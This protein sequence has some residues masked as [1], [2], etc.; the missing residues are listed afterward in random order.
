MTQYIKNG[1]SF[2]P[3]NEENLNIHKNLPIGNYTVKQDQ[4]KEFFL[5]RIDDFKIDF[6]LYGKIPS[7]TKRIINTFQDR[8]N[9]TGVLLAG[10]KGGGKSLLA[11]NLAIHAREL[12]I[13]TIVINQP[14]CGET[15]NQFIQSIVQPC[16]IVFDEFEK[17][18]DQSEQRQ[19]L[20]LLDGVYPSKK[21][22]ILTCN[23]KYHIDSHLKNR[24]GRIYYF[25][26]FE[27]VNKTF[28]EEYCE[29]NLKQ[30][31]YI[32][33]LL[34][35]PMLFMEFNFDM[36]KNIVEEMN[37]YGEDPK[38]VMGYLNVRPELDESTW[39][40]IELWNKD[41]QIDKEKIKEKYFSGNPLKDYIEINYD[42]DDDNY[43]E[44]EFDQ[45]DLVE[46]NPLTNQLVFVN[47]ENH[48]LILN[49]NNYTKFSFNQV[50]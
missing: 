4:F 39:Y 49:R 2:I 46:V 19:I 25:I 17:T 14:W 27:S 12:N 38:T 44:C 15:F 42:L 1:N 40:T 30:K 8:P 28:I 10:T 33:D 3:K 32:K 7:L 34:K 9:S 36:L 22:F 20:T 45:G 24:P 47:K 43:M 50:F 23:N 11:K 16:I 6:K 21:L 29:D 48:K 37:R 31:H 35:L 41:K 18:Y 26:E 5:E 13:P